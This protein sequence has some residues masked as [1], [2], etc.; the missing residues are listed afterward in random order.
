M[1][2]GAR[3]RSRN[4]PCWTKLATA[5]L[6]ELVAIVTDDHGSKLPRP[7]FNNTMLMLFEDI[8][9]LEMLTNSQITRLLKTLWSRYQRSNSAD[10]RH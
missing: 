10:Q 1:M 5:Q 3:M 4:E 6:H 7:E 2:D 9:G 8:A